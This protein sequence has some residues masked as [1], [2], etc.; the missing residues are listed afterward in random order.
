MGKRPG[1]CSIGGC[2]TIGEPHALRYWPGGMTETRGSL[3][4][5]SVCE[6]HWPAVQAKLADPRHWR[7]VHSV[8]VLSFRGTGVPPGS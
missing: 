7:A 5:L 8:G 3:P 4:T 1:Q 6:T 2:M